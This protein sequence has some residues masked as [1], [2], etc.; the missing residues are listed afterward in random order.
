M[1]TGATFTRCA[2]ACEMRLNFGEIVTYLGVFQN[3]IFGQRDSQGGCE[4]G[5]T[6]GDVNPD[7]QGG[8]DVNPVVQNFF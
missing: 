1:I 4:S 8:G 3:L 2:S 7:S 6:R 5:F